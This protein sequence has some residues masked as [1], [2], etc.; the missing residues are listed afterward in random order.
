MQGGEGSTQDMGDSQKEPGNQN[1]GIT[2]RC[3]SL[4]K[5]SPSSSLCVYVCMCLCVCEPVCMCLCMHVL[6]A[7]VC[8]HVTSEDQR[9]GKKRV[10]C[11]LFKVKL[12]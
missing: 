6:C 3:I 9:R 10:A 11:V 12:N 4:G 5:L 1:S 7:F 2:R 8:M